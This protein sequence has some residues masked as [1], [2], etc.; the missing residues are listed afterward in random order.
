MTPTLHHKIEIV[1]R[2]MKATVGNEHQS[3]QLD[4]ITMKILVFRVT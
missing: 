1:R 2:V 4:M 3:A